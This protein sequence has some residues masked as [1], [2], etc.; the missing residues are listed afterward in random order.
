MGVYRKNGQLQKFDPL[1]EANSRDL[2]LSFENTLDKN[3]RTMKA[4]DTDVFWVE[5]R[6]FSK[7][8]FGVS[9]TDSVSIQTGDGSL[10]FRADGLYQ[11]HGHLKKLFANGD[12]SHQMMLLFDD[13]SLHYAYQGKLLWSQEESLSQINQVEVYDNSAELMRSQQTD[14]EYVKHMNQKVE[15]ADVPQR[16]IQRYTENIKHLVHSVQKLFSSFSDQADTSIQSA[17]DSAL[18][19]SGFRKL[20]IVLAKPGKVHAISS[21]T[22]SVAWSYYVPEKVPTKVFILNEVPKEFKINSSEG[23]IGVVFDDEIHYLSP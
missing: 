3:C 8:F 9:C 15:L 14:L 21:I 6:P 2:N 16:I 11:K 22:G 12:G 18:D 23:L 5:A 19:Y 13:L 7:L 1:Q 20:M 4:K 10:I 17:R